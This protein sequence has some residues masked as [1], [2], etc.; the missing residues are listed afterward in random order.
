ML[1]RD[2][3][4]TLRDFVPSTAALYRRAELV[5]ATTGYN[6]TTD[7]FLYARRAVLIPRV[8][9]RQEQLIR[10]RR[11]AELGLATCLGPDEVSPE[12][13]FEAIQAARR[14]EPLTRARAEGRLALD[15]AEHFAEFCAGLEVEVREG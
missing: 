1:A 8:L 10:A 5:V 6:T 2:L 14:D 13:L 12:R 3:P 11:L 7:L 15:G 9:Y 4:V